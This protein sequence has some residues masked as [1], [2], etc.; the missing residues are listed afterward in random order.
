MGEARR[1]GTEAERIQQALQ[2]KNTGLLDLSVAITGQEA[3]MDSIQILDAEQFGKISNWMMRGLSEALKTKR[4]NLDV[5]T[6][7]GW[8]QEDGSLIVR[9]LHKEVI[10]DEFRIPK[11]QWRVATPEVLAQSKLDLSS[12]ESATLL[13]E[14]GEIAKKMEG[15]PRRPAPANIDELLDHVLMVIGREP[16]GVH[17]LDSMSQDNPYMRNAADAW[18]ASGTKYITIPLNRRDG[19]AVPNIEFANDEAKLMAILDRQALASPDMSRTGLSITGVDAG[20]K[21][22]AF[23]RWATK[24]GNVILQK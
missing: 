3:N 2:N 9:L 6:A 13:K 23:D 22:A 17:F 24:S 1:R 7:K 16:A 14:M 12:P 18:I 10:N 11:E 4:L 15:E 20:V 8:T 19:M 21:K 5:F